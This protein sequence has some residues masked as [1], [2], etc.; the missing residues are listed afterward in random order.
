MTSPSVS[1]AFWRVCDMT[2]EYVGRDSFIRVTWLA[3]TMSPS[4]STVSRQ[5]CDMTQEHVGHDSFTFVTRLATSGRCDVTHW[6]VGHDSFTF[7]TRLATSIS[8]SVSLAFWRLW[9]DS[10][11]W[12]NSCIYGTWLI[13]MCDM[14]GHYDISLSLNGILAGATWLMYICHE[15]CMWDVTRWCVWHD[16]LIRVIRLI[17][18][19][20]DWGMGWLWLVGSLKI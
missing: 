19:R 5:V 17:H 3:T 18:M 14:T 13:Y 10:F 2:H 11:T 8:P 12:H 6:C 9:N 1:T 20:R 15:S 16:S 7:M 4:V